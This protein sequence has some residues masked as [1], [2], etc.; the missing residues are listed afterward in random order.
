[1]HLKL[2]ILLKNSVRKIVVGVKACA[3][4]KKRKTE[5]AWWG[6]IMEGGHNS[7]KSHEEL[8]VGSREKALGMQN[9]AQ[10]PRGFW[11]G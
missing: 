8:T 1:M 9:T 2:N 5:M 10:A 6:R 4:I 3:H 11:D 7:S